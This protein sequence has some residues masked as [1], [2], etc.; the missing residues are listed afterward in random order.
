MLFSE[1]ETTYTSKYPEVEARMGMVIE[2]RR[3]GS[4]VG[5]IVIVAKSWES[6]TVKE[7]PTK[8]TEPPPSL[9]KLYVCGHWKEL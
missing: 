5:A 4:V 9:T 7:L 3:K 1:V 8:F 6:G 2:L